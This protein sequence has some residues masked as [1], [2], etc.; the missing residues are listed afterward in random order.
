[1]WLTTPG[2]SSGTRPRLP[3]CSRRWRSSQT[4]P[5]RWRCWRASCSPPSGVSTLRLQT[6]APMLRMVWPLRDQDALA[7]KAFLVEKRTPGGNTARE[8]R[9][10]RRSAI[11]HLHFKRTVYKSG[12]GKASQRLEY[13]TRQPERTLT[14][15]ERQL[16]YV[17]EGREDLV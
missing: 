7:R 12:G 13:I 4:H 6:A 3:D 2:S 15:A 16:R 14:A 17:R 5:T 9:R 10:E 11:A 1:P 8:A